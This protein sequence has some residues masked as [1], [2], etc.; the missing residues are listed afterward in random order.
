MVAT[1]RQATGSRW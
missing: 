1:H